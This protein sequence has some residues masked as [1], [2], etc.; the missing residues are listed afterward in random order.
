MEAAEASI[1]FYMVEEDGKVEI[2]SFHNVIAQV[3]PRYANVGMW[4]VYSNAIYEPLRGHSDL[5]E[6]L[7]DC[8]VLDV[9]IHLTDRSL[10]IVSVNY[11]AGRN[12][13]EEQKNPMHRIMTMPFEELIM[14]PCVQA[15]PRGLVR[16]RRGEAQDPRRRMQIRM[17]ALQTCVPRPAGATFC[18]NMDLITM[19]EAKLNAYDSEQ[20][21]VLPS[22]ADTS[23][24]CYML[25][26]LVNTWIAQKSHNEFVGIQF[27]APGIV[28]EGNRRY[29]HRALNPSFFVYRD[30]F[31]GRWILN[32]W[33][34]IRRFPACRI[35]YTVP[36][37]R[38]IIGSQFG[39]SNV[40]DQE[41]VVYAWVPLYEG[42]EY[43]RDADRP[44]PTQDIE[45][46]PQGVYG[47]D[48]DTRE[49]LYDQF[50]SI[51]LNAADDDDASVAS[52]VYDYPMPASH[53]EEEVYEY[54]I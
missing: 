29:R 19:N 43:A 5:R 21:I 1:A 38:F 8:T 15:L 6:A 16:P 22:V 41:H 28:L 25:S 3:L 45:Q 35:F 24:Q 4:P 26:D 27:S 39:V 12:N 2:L 13:V 9:Y 18:T 7:R 37:G 40:H 51:E 10:S 52:E 50:N 53:E 33:E 54:L 32:P 44:G 47:W 23:G 30:I 14:L 17:A 11:L 34:V 36:L 48:V 49:Y 42:S 46:F 31:L 20:I